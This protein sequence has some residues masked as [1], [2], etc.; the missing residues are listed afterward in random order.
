LAACAAPR[1]SSPKA[2][3]TTATATAAPSVVTSNI[4]RRDYAGSQACASC[5]SD[6]YD[7]FM[8]APMHNMTRLPIAG[9][10]MPPFVGRFRFKDDAV[11]FETSGDARLMHIEATGQPERTFKVT[12]VIGGHYRED[13]AGVEI[14]GRDGR[15]E[16][17]ER[18]LPASY[19]LATNTWRYKGYSVLGPERPGLRPGGVWNKTCIF[20]H[21]TIPYFDDILGAISDRALGPY[22]GEVVDPLLP[23]ERRAAWE[24]TDAA[25][26]ASAVA[27][28]LAVLGA[29]PQPGAAAGALLQ[30]VRGRFGGAH[31]VELGI[32]CESCHGGSAE[33]VKHNATKPSFAPRASFLRVSLPAKDRDERVAGINR[34]C[35]R[36]H[37]VLFTRYPWT[38]EGG[39][40]GG[41]SPGG[42]N[43]NSGEA[44]DFMLGGCASAMA[45]SDCHDPH[46][47]NKPHTAELEARAD[48]VCVRCHKELAT[49]A[50]QQAHTHHDP[51]GAGGRCLGCH[52]PRKNLSL[53]NRLTRYHRI[54][55]PTED[56]K[57]AGDRP[58]ECALC[59]GDKPP[60]TLVATMEAWW[61]KR[62][63][64]APLRALY[65]DDLAHA[66][67]LVETLARG[68][69]HEQA[70]ALAL[71]GARGDR[72]PAALMA[73]QLTHTTP[74][75][76]YYAQSALETLLGSKAPFDVHDRDDA[77]VAAASAWLRSAGIRAVI[78]RSP[79]A[80]P[81]TSDSDID[82]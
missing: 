74:I 14:G 61:H 63:D 22:Q 32:G 16:K 77:I 41:P 25:A 26:L 80:A 62:Y 20:C 64:R 44:R 2:P 19:F 39:R 12:R 45:C 59:H 7:A 5:H 37:Q 1:A 24:V 10:P 43:I 81:L 58:L 18:I 52:M 36:C 66:D 23:P 78:P 76:R 75:V 31:L 73:A 29:R 71:L 48:G 35:A 38:W 50:A 65:G 60:E 34:A 9:T 56:A 13:F 27:D 54:A 46:A 3:G 17:T 30:A 55:S 79:S 67:V 8:A 72:K 47:H 51:A 68:K 21:N 4:L 33:H 69:P 82:P 70:L 49:A 6:V 40:R 11:R 28:E 15:T 57:V 42:S 53:D